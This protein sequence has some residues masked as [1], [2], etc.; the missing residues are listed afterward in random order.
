MSIPQLI[1]QQKQFFATQQTKSV[2]FRKKSLQK[3]LKEIIR[4]ENDILKAL[5]NDF[6][7]VG[8]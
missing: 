6:K 7:K 4:R 1:E 3:L 2:A 8:I 5:H